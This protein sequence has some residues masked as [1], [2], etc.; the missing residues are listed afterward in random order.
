MDRFKQG[1]RSGKKTGAGDVVLGLRYSR[2]IP[3]TFLSGFS[4]GT[5]LRIAEQ[6]GY[7]P[8]P[9]GFRTF[10]YGKPAY[11]IDVATGFH[12]P[13]MDMNVSISMLRFPGAAQADSAFATDT[14]YDTGFGY[15]GIGRPDPTGLAE[16]L[17]QNQFHTSV[18]L[19]MPVKPW[20]S[21]LLEF[22][23][24]SFIGEPG[25]DGIAT[26]AMGTRLGTPDGLNMSVGIDYALGGP[27]P[28]KT[29]LFRFRVPTLSYRGIKALLTM[30]PAD[31][32]VTAKNTVVAFTD[33]SKQDITYF[34]EEDLKTALLGSLRADNFL[35]IASNRQVGDVMYQQ[36]LVPIP[37]RPQQLGVRLGATHLVT[38][39]ILEYRIDRLANITVPFIVG[40][41]QT[42]FTLTCRAS[43]TD[44]VTG[45]SHP[46]GTITATVV[47]PRGVVFFPAGQSSDISQL[48]EPECL[49]AEKELINRWVEQCTAAIVENSRLF[50][51]EPMRA[52]VGIDE[53]ALAE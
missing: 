45:E 18:G 50:G 9:L 25:R 10:S 43:V 36:T 32:D 1:E 46:L 48:S 24:I 17:F 8:E 42:D 27:I 7:G 26:L 29:V 38:T 23:T 47:R 5:H 40:F 31:I 51:W 21:M 3:G 37:E 28:D 19:S 35:R 4:V 2:S 30:R 34:Y 14:F 13:R 22:N 41:P 49:K 53:G 6:L 52:G 15:M 11:S 39:E 20:L 44:L 16:G 33:F 12:L